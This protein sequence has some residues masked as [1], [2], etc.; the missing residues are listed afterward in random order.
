MSAGGMSRKGATLLLIISALISIIAGLLVLGMDSS[1]PS[2]WIGPAVKKAC[3]VPKPTGNTGP[4]TLV[5]EPAKRDVG[6]VGQGE[7]RLCGRS[8]RT[9]SL[10]F[11]GY[12][13]RGT[14]HA[15]SETTVELQVGRVGH[16]HNG[17]L[18]VDQRR[19]SRLP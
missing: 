2:H 18:Y 7:P 3:L 17:H 11:A 8:T 19:V 15:G 6:V 14:P 12:A 16:V 10:V 13:E 4:P 9:G 5:G 1:H